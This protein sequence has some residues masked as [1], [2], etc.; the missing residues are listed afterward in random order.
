MD[1][2]I[3]QNISVS[4]GVKYDGGAYFSGTLKHLSTSIAFY[5]GARCE[6][7]ISLNE[8][9]AVHDNDVIPPLEGNARIHH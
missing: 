2:H 6:P 8:I 9:V 4:I 3:D 7:E 1:S 5:N